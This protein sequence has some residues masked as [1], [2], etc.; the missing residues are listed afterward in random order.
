V[1]NRRL[2]TLDAYPLGATPLGLLLSRDIRIDKDVEIGAVT[3]RPG[4]F[5][6]IARRAGKHGEGQI[7]LDFNDT[8]MALAGW[9]ITDAQGG[10]TRVKLN[11]FG[12]SKAMPN[13]YFELSPTKGGGAGP[14]EK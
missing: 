7:S 13:W 10:V 8:P 1:L 12:P 2:G 9:S 14:A 4:G 6:I 3:T 5:S 11:D